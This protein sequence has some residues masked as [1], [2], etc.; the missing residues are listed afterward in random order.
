MVL[1][2]LNRFK[3]GKI[4]FKPA[5]GI[6]AFNLGQL[7]HGLNQVVQRPLAN[8]DPLHLP[9]PAEEPF[10]RLPARTQL[11]L[12]P[13]TNE[14]W[15]HV[16]AL[17]HNPRLR[18]TLP[19]QYRLRTLALALEKRWKTD[20]ERAVSLPGGA[21]RSVEICGRDVAVCGRGI[22]GAVR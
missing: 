22:D 4:E 18:A 15:Y 19:L 5:S 14:A 21:V 6:N 2:G 9:D 16:Q 3:P 8:P 17:S 12:T 11:E 1:T 13:A 20:A 10:V 7:N